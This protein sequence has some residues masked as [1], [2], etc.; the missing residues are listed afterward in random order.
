MSKAINQTV[1]DVLD[2]KQ[3]AEYLHQNERTIRLWRKRGM[4]HIKLSAKSVLYRRS[5]LDKWLDARAVNAP[6][7]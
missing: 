3:V 6:L 7:N 4:P 1:S 5:D 2:V